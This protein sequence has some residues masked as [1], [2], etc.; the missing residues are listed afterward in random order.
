MGGTA[1]R[2]PEEDAAPRSLAPQSGVRG[3]QRQHHLGTCVRNAES[4]TP[5]PPSQ[6]LPFNQTPR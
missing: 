6:N 3:W 5:S 2:D 1:C 4:R